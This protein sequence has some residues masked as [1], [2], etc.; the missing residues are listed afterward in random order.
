MLRFVRRALQK[1]LDIFLQK[2]KENIIISNKINFNDVDGSDFDA[3]AVCRFYNPCARY[4]A[5]TAV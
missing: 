3:L 5:N 2:L 4:F 1:V